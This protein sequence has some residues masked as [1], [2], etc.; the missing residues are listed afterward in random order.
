MNFDDLT[1]AISQLSPEYWTKGS[2]ALLEKTLKDQKLLPELQKAFQKAL[3]NQQKTDL[4]STQYAEALVEFE[5]SIVSLPS[6]DTSGYLKIHNS[7]ESIQSKIGAIDVV[8]K[9]NRLEA[10]KITDQIDR[11]TTRIKEKQTKW[12]PRKMSG[13]RLKN[14]IAQVNKFLDGY[15]K[16]EGIE[17]KAKCHQLLQGI[18]DIEIETDV[19]ELVFNVNQLKAFTTK[20]KKKKKKKAVV[21]THCNE[22]V[23]FIVA[24]HCMTCFP[25]DAHTRMHIIS[26]KES[27]LIEKG[28]SRATYEN[29]REELCKY[30]EEEDWT[31]EKA[32]EFDKCAQKCEKLLKDIPY[33]EEDDDDDDDIV[34]MNV[35]DDYIIVSSEEDISVEAEKRKPTDSDILSFMQTPRGKNEAKRQ[36]IL[37]LHSAKDYV[38]IAAEMSRYELIVKYEPDNR[39]CWPSDGYLFDTKEEAEQKG[40]NYIKDLD[41]WSF[42]VQEH[43]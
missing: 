32:K 38:G 25:D 1:N 33:V 17:F 6:K 3:E 43:K 8:T 41:G 2:N 27:Q 37:D 39:E 42:K 29:A 14:Y 23:P 20:K 19:G 9:K 24:K 10:K 5:K 30:E 4:I 31:K 40:Q 26:V 12:K 7:V 21:C 35:D 28:K 16:V 22:E 18:V 15:T 34:P 11:V 13:Q 36:K